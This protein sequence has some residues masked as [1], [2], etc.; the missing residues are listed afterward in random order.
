MKLRTHPSEKSLLASI[1]TVGPATSVAEN[2][3]TSTNKFLGTTENRSHIYK[4]FSKYYKLNK[5]LAKKLIQGGRPQA[6]QFSAHMGTMGIEPAIS[7]L[8][9]ISSLPHPKI[10]CDYSLCWIFLNEYLRL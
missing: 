10:N 3:A 4:S 5:K 6:T 2:R 7:G 9:C 1:E 8:V